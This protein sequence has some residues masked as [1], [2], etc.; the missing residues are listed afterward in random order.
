M[1]DLM[2]VCAHFKCP[3]ID[4]LMDKMVN[5]GPQT[6]AKVLVLDMDETLIHAKFMLTPE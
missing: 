6:R 3:T 4:E 2:K 5:F 1:I